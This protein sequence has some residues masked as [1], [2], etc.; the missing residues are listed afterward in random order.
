VARVAEGARGIANRA[1]VAAPLATCVVPIEG[2]DAGRL[3]EVN[4]AF[5]TFVGRDRSELLGAPSERFI[6]PDDRARASEVAATI[7]GGFSELADVPLRYVRR[8]GAARWGNV[9]MRTFD[10]E[11]R[12]VMV[13]QIVDIDHEYRA[14]RDLAAREERYRSFAELLQEGI[15]T[16][17][18]DR[19]TTFVNE[20]MATL[21][22]YSPNE[23]IGHHASEFELEE[24]HDFFTELF[25]QRW[26]GAVERDVI[27]LPHRDGH[28]V[29]F[30][31]SAGP[32][33][34]GTGT[35]VG[36][37]ALL[38]DI[39]E[40]RAAAI[41]LQESERRLRA[42]VERSWDIITVLRPGGLWWSPNPSAAA[43]SLGWPFAQLSRKDARAALHPDDYDLVARAYAETLE[44]V[45][46]PDAPVVLRVLRH[47][48]GERVFECLFQDL[49][50]EPSIGG[51]LINTR[52]ITERVAAETALREQERRVAELSAAARAN[53]LE[54]ELQRARRLESVGRLAGG[55]A[56]D[57]NNLL[58]V[59]LRC[60]DAL[61]ARADERRGEDAEDAAAIRD[62]AERGSLLV[63]RLLRL[64]G[65]NAPASAPF[66]LNVSLEELLRL[67]A[68]GLGQVRLEFTPEPEPCVIRAHRDEVEQ[69]VL[70]L[71][72]NARDASADGA[73]VEVS[74]ATAVLSD[75]EPA[76]LLRVADHGKGMTD[77]VRALAV[78]PFFTTK[79]DASGNGLGLTTVLATVERAGGTLQI[80]SEPGRGTTVTLALPRVAADVVAG[81]GAMQA[82]DGDRAAVVAGR[83]LVVDD[84]PC[85]RVA[86]VD[87]L[88]DAG[89]DP[90]AAASGAEA[91]SLIRSGLRPL[92]VVSD[93]RMPGLSGEDLAR[94]LAHEHSIPT[95]LMSGWPGGATSAERGVVLT[96]PLVRD[97]LIAAIA[98]AGASAP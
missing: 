6:H 97:Q 46:G 50:D 20:R 98:A 33:R 16:T 51:V 74:T 24:D 61:S 44:G 7:V 45:R 88:R 21:L 55:V 72:L 81:V 80:E 91:M 15:W 2:D 36:S 10:D 84:D 83:V 65:P 63:R 22:G 47:G 25:D 73:R 37:I 27:R 56:H 67:A 32:L 75:G 58:G 87:M 3:I 89:F 19:I 8:D 14:H 69:A 92:V 31:V 96:K 53:A 30:S 41:A 94:W 77:D 90:V 43:T 29:W 42:L 34:D 79:H 13:A 35:I 59:I 76:V 66:D 57:F 1:F 5:C 95:V 18:T 48:G 4:D 62:A 60:A 82:S 70:N 11:D 12:R 85:V 93:V 28:V 26:A 9:F 68:R 71:L 64:G 78:E 17:D 23:I 86:T 52:D 54:I 40:Q 39:T 49:R 38:V